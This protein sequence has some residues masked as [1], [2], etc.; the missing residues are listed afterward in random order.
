MA[1]KKERQVE[2]ISIVAFF[3]MLW[4][5]MGQYEFLVQHWMKLGVYLIPFLF[6][7]SVKGADK[8]LSHDQFFLSG[9]MLISYIVHQFEEHWVDIYGNNYAFSGSVNSLLSSATG[10][11][12]PLLSPEGIFVINTS[13]VWLVGALSILGSPRYVFPSL[14]MAAI[15]LVNAVAHIALWILNQ[16]YNPGV[17]TSVLIF[18][19]IAMWFYKVSIDQKWAVKSLVIGSLAWSVLGHVAMVWGTV[20][21]NHWNLFPEFVYFAVLFFVSIAPFAYALMGESRSSVTRPSS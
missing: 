4:L 10:S 15:I 18:L 21:A 9:L 3:L 16:Q 6:L 7:I 8:Q 20:G 1:F 5:P 11:S 14:C 2:A 12:S 19:P 17:L 13:L